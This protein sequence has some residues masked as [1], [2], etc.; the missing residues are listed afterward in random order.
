MAVLKYTLTGCDSLTKSFFFLK[1]I[2]L[3]SY[4]IFLLIQLSSEVI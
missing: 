2:Y 3:G 1:I 4:P